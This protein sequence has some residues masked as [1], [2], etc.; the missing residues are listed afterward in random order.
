LVLKVR[1]SSKGN[2]VF[3]VA[4]FLVEMSK[5]SKVSYLLVAGAPTGS[6]AMRIASRYAHL[7]GVPVWA[8]PT[9]PSQP[10]PT[11]ALYVPR[12]RQ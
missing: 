6:A 10:E 1:T 2:Q 4:D 7:F 12:G 9:H 3:T 8:K 11:I 5:L